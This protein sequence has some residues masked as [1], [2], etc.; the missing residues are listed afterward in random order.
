MS[1]F[2]CVFCFKLLMLSLN[3]YR[4]TQNKFATF[5]VHLNWAEQA[6]IMWALFSQL[7]QI[8]LS[9]YFYLEKLEHSLVCSN[10]LCIRFSYLKKCERI[11]PEAI[12][13]SNWLKF[14][15]KMKLQFCRWKKYQWIDKHCAIVVLWLSCEKLW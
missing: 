4:I 9:D 10:L 1:V 6:G 3:T 15:N 2:L 5:F 11:L 8:I 14:F 13:S 12:H 7:I